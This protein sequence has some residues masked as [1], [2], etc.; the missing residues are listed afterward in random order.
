MSEGHICPNC[1]RHMKFWGHTIY[2]PNQDE[3]GR[4]PIILTD[5]QLLRM[6]AAEPKRVKVPRNRRGHPKEHPELFPN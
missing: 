3:C 2:C 6:K 1:R 5:E 4:K